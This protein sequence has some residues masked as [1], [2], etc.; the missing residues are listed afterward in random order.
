MGMHIALR[1]QAAIDRPAG[2]GEVYRRLV[3]ARGQLEAEHA[4]ME[5][6]GKALWSAQREGREPDQAAYLEC[7]QK[8]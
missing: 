7:L 8:L 3:A 5:C 2:I 4:M 6:L 1:E